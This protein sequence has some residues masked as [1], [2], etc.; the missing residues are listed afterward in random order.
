MAS[1]PT[2]DFAKFTN[3]SN[4]D[5]LNLGNALVK[6]FRDHGF[7][8]L[9]NHGLPDATTEALLNFSA[10]FFKLPAEIKDDIVC[11]RS[12]HPQR[13]WSRVGSE[14]TSKLRKENIINRNASE[15]T[16]EREHFDAGPLDDTQYPN[17]WP[18]EDALPGFRDFMEHTYQQCQEIS[19]RIV[20]AIEVGLGLQPRALVRRCCPAASEIRMNRYPPVSMERLADGRVKRTWP[21]TD[22]G[23]IT[24]LFQDHVGGL[25]LEDRAQPGTFVPVTPVKVGPGQKSEMVVNISDTFQ[26]WTNGVIKAGLHQVSA[27]PAYKTSAADGILPERHSCVFF[28][29]ACRNT[30]AGPLP[31]FVTPENPAHYDEITALEYQQRMT[32]EL[33]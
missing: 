12:P 1:L 21:H 33:Y 9:I 7:V 20:A 27:P 32:K 22:F 6:S 30:S 13:G 4:L 25:E 31:E 23:I 18:R 2:L 28:F 11:I 17:L 26:R 29:K 5:Q 3:G 19:L 14:Q 8:K 16:D 15:L 10:E 24:L